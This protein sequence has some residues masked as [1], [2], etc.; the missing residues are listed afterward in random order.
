MWLVAAGLLTGCGGSS[1]GNG[2]GNV[3]ISGQITFDRI[4]FKATVGAGLDPANP[5]RLPA[6]E[7]VVEVLDAN[8]RAV[9]GSTSTD[10]SGSYSVSV[11]ANRSMFVRAKAQMLKAGAAPTWNFRV[12]NNTNNDALYVLDSSAF[13]PGT[14]SVTRHLHAPTGWGTI[15]Y[16]GLRTAAPFAILD[17]IYRAKTLVLSAEPELSFPALDLF[18]A[19]SNR[20][21]VGG[22]C[23][24]DGDVN[25]SFYIGANSISADALTPGCSRSSVPAGIYL[26]GDAADSDEFDQHVIAHEF[27]HY[28]EDQLG[29]SDSL[30]GDHSLTQRLD[31]R[32]AFSEGW[33]NAFA[34]MVLD[35]PRYRDSMGFNTD[36]GF[37]LETDQTIAEGWYSQASVGEILW[38]LFDAANEPHDGVALGFGAIH[39]VMR[40]AQVETDAVTSIYSFSRGLL[41]TQPA[42]AQAIQ[43]LLN[44]ESIGVTDEFGSGEINDGDVAGA[45]PIF[46]P[47]SLNQSPVHVCTSSRAGSRDLNKLGNRRLLRLELPA[48][49]LVTIHASGAAAVPA[50]PAT[51]PDIYVLRRGQ[52]LYSG[53]T[54]TPNSE[55][56]S[57][58]S[59]AAGTYIIEV[60]DYDL[61]STAQEQR[62]MDVS[63]TGTIS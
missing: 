34:A 63:V 40:T 5:Q 23:P 53:R 56:L 36:T 10:A 46:V 57:Q 51:D 20:D 43:A 38:D 39:R 30:G 48:P 13:N 4:S 11:P 14:T 32:L 60:Y 16:T 19:A 35:D 45:L 9:L 2:G 33:G 28:F 54:G 7:V 15:S 1:G 12:R 3:T 29:R 42:Q 49:A 59:L 58:I 52:V 31:L 41:A 47:V 18:W 50:L 6:R 62:C 25:T 37:N 55:T 22:F 61:G 44:A 8:T 17:T 24:A 21:V 26:L 27:G